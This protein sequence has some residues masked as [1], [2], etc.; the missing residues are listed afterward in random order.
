MQA[1]AGLDWALLANLLLGHYLSL[2]RRKGS[3]MK[4]ELVTLSKPPTPQK[5]WITAEEIL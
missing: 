3:I 4:G 1:G 2:G 5:G